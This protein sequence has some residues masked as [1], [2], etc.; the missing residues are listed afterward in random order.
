MGLQDA[1][2]RSQAEGSRLCV[3]GAGLRLK[4]QVATSKG[5][6]AEVCLCKAQGE[7]KAVTVTLVK[8]RQASKLA[9]DELRLDL[10]RSRVTSDDLRRALQDGGVGSNPAGNMI[11]VR[12][13]AGMDTPL[14]TDPP[15][16]PTASVTSRVH[17]T[18]PRG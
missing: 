15:A 8:E 6:L 12:L 1:L 7:L 2:G 4:W 11:G 10:A 3:E 14:V 16:T 5:D 13:Q 17:R 18:H 9:M